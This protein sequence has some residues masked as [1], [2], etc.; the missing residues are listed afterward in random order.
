MLNYLIIIKTLC[1]YNYNK[2]NKLKV[3]VV[4]FYKIKS[5]LNK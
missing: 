2:Y 5:K 4:L 3:H 1:I